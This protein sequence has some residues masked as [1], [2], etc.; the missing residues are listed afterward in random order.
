MFSFWKTMFENSKIY[1]HRCSA[2]LAVMG[3]T[4]SQTDK[5]IRIKYTVYKW[6]CDIC[7]IKVLTRGKF[8][9]WSFL[10][11]IYTQGHFWRKFYTCSFLGGGGIPN[12]LTILYKSLFPSFLKSFFQYLSQTILKWIC[13]YLQIIQNK[14]KYNC[15][16]I[17]QCCMMHLI[18]TNNNLNSKLNRL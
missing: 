7:N 5:L 12:F 4:T 15:S 3:K 17:K 2:L 16:N 18:C 11:R 10:G 1:Q 8:Y 6:L 13:L 9:T 14:S